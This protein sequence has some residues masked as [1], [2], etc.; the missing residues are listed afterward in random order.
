VPQLPKMGLDMIKR[1]SKGFQTEKN[2]YCMIFNGL[3]MFPPKKGNNIK[4]HI[5]T[6]FSTKKTVWTCHR[7][8]R[9]L[10]TK[11]RDFTSPTLV[12]NEKSPAVRTQVCDREKSW[13]RDVFVCQTYYQVIIFSSCVS[14]NKFLGWVWNGLKSQF[15][16]QYLWKWVHPLVRTVWLIQVN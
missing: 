2:W 1:S 12:R 6:Q 3:N 13:W 10:R 5:K 9:E 8:W 4:K 11:E 15:S 16:D 14:V 7:L